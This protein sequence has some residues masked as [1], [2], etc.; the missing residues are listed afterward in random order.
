MSKMIILSRNGVEL[1]HFCTPEASE[2]LLRDF[3]EKYDSVVV[4]E[5]EDYYR[6]YV[7]LNKKIGVKNEFN[8]AL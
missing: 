2:A 4:L 6:E 7:G 1:S 3:R 5:I 8:K